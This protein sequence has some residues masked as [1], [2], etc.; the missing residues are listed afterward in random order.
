MLGT[1][2]SYSQISPYLWAPTLPVLRVVD[3]VVVV[4]GWLLLDDLRAGAG[5]GH[6]RAEEDVDE[7]HDGEEDAEGDAQPQQPLVGHTAERRRAVH[8]PRCD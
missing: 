8:R 5:A 2:S 1:V 7:E 4:D 6:G 3:G